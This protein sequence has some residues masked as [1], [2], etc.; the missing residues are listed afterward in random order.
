LIIY[1]T[2]ALIVYFVYKNVPFGNFVSYYSLDDLTYAVVATICLCV[3]FVTLI[4]QIYLLTAAYIRT[5][6]I[7]AFYN[8][9]IIENEEIIKSKK[10]KNK[11][12]MLFF[13][14]IVGLVGLI[15]YLVYKIVRRVGGRK[16][17]KITVS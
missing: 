17:T 1:I 11:R 4:S 7:D 14:T 5:S 6:R 3:V 9:Q 13:L 10:E 15:F 8:F 16:A 2:I 12:D